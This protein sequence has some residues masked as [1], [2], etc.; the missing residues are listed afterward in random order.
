MVFFPFR[1]FFNIF[2]LISYIKS[3]IYLQSFMIYFMI[4]YDEIYRSCLLWARWLISMCEQRWHSYENDL[5]NFPFT[6]HKVLWFVS[7]DKNFGWWLGCRTIIIW[8]KIIW[9]SIIIFSMMLIIC[10]LNSDPCE[11]FIFCVGLIANM[12]TILW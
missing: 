6:Y 1:I 11:A 4:N 2:L 9:P 7:T 5:I 3:E 10:G 8:S 12:K